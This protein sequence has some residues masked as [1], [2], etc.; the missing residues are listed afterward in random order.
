MEAV[1]SPPFLATLVS[2]TVVISDS[3]M[4]TNRKYR[5]HGYKFD[6]FPLGNEIFVGSLSIVTRLWDGLRGSVIRFRQGP[7]MDP[8]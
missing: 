7:K 1:C 4:Q 6:C 3:G 2:S 5:I 8:L